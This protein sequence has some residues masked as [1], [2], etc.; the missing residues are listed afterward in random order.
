VL[1][2]CC[3]CVVCV[4]YVCCMCVV[5]VLYVCC[6]CVVCVLYVCC[7]CV[8]WCVDNG[9][10]LEPDGHPTNKGHEMFYKELASKWIYE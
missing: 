4:L 1:Y 2:V 6:M 8:E 9:I 3:M 10:E 5:C 7:M